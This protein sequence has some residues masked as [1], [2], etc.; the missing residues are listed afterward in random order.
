MNPV[1]I[2][3]SCEAFRHNG[4]N[5][6]IRETWLK[7]WGHLVPHKFLLGRGCTDPLDDELVVDE[8]DGYENTLSKCR[9]AQRW[10]NDIGYSHMFLACCDTYVAVPRLLASGFEN[11]DCVGSMLTD[12]PFPG[13]GCGYWLSF[14]ANDAMFHDVP[15]TDAHDLWTGRALARA[16]IPLTHDERY[17]TGGGGPT[18]FPSRDKTMWERGLISAHLGQMKRYDAQQ[19][20]DCHKAFMEGE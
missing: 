13:G 18:L 5:D 14:R 2:I 19:M 8:D 9:A 12:A 3:L 15:D 10:S 11:Y 20:F 16:G 7:E 6:A 4:Y 17:W 1:I